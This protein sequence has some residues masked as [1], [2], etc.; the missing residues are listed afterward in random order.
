MAVK[1]LDIENRTYYFYSDLLNV[2]NFEPG[3]FKLDKKVGK[4]LMFIILV[5]L[6]KVNHQVGK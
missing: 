1:Q 2:L 3:N 4:T 6:I 5:M